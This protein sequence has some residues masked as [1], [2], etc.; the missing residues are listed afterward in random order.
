MPEP[1]VTK[2][3]LDDYLPDTY[4]DAKFH[5]DVIREFFPRICEVAYR[6]FTRLLF[7]SPQL[8]TPEGVAPIL[9]INT[10][11]HI[12]SRNDVFFMRPKN[13]IFH[14]DPISPKN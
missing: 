6:V 10:S 12:A 14:F 1:M 4:R 2:I 13:K 8:A 11:K 7:W 3:C 9:T 5:C